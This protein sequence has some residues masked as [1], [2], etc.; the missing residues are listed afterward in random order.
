MEKINPKQASAVWQRVTAGREDA[1]NV[2]EMVLD[3][4]ENA[5][6]LLQLSRRVQ[7]PRSA[8]LHALYREAQSST[9]CLKGISLLLGGSRPVL[10]NT[11]PKQE[12]MEAALRGCYGRAMR[13][14]AKLESCRQDAQYGPAFGR[15]ANIQQ[16]LCSRLL[17]LLGSWEQA[18]G[19]K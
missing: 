1:P 13:L 4:W 16:G 6:T 10:G 12:P 8:Q 9:D 15:L 3:S 17:E 7:G 19:R 11:P 18:K 2:E 5:R 14:L